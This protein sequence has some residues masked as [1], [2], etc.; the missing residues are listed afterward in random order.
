MVIETEQGDAIAIRHMVYFSM[1]YDHR[2]IDGALGATFLNSLAKE[3]ENFDTGR[4][5]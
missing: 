2:I 5:F 4:S 3:L 1:S